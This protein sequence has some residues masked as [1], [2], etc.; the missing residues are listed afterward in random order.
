MRSHVKDIPV[1]LKT[2]LS[3]LLSFM[4]LSSHK[5]QA[6]VQ[7]MQFSF[8]AGFASGFWICIHLLK[9]FS[10][11]STTRNTKKVPK[12]GWSQN[13][14]P[15]RGQQTEGQWSTRRDKPV[16]VCVSSHT[17]THLCVFNHKAAVIM[18]NCKNNSILKI[19]GSPKISKDQNKTKN[20]NSHFTDTFRQITLLCGY[21]TNHVM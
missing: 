18:Q 17:G 11:W 3:S 4:W 13:N 20:K 12:H 21:Y 7:N 5:G 6:T 19:V 9:V 15:D 14:G 10:D 8:G 16:L 2:T 1:G